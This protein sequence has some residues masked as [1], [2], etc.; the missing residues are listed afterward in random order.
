MRFMGWMQQQITQLFS[1]TDSTSIRL[2]RTLDD[3]EQY[4]IAKHKEQREAKALGELGM[5]PS[6]P[7][8][9]FSKT[10]ENAKPNS[11]SEKRS[12]RASVPGYTQ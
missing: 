3:L 4:I 5:V 7:S 12:P 8:L 6:Q 1:S 9:S 11:L 10:P 2:D